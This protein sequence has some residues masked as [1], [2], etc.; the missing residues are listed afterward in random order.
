MPCVRMNRLYTTVSSEMIVSHMMVAMRCVRMNKPHM[1][2]SRT[3]PSAAERATM[4]K[5]V[6]FLKASVKIS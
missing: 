2:S 5:S 4:K 3:G 6:N 1:P